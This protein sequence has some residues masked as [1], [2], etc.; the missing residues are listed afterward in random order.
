VT[1][2]DNP[3]ARAIQRWLITHIA[4]LLGEDQAS[5]DVG[6]PFVNYGLGSTDAVILS[7]DLEAWLGRDLP[8]TLLW[9]FP[10]IAAL[11]SYLAEA[12]AQAA[13]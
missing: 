2:T 8:A 12:P 13:A 7:G 11:A 6:E 4:Q 10:T 1:N 5:I 9:D 3:S